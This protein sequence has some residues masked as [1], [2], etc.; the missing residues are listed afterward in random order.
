MKK[1][2]LEAYKLEFGIHKGTEEETLEMVEELDDDSEL[3]QLILEDQLRDKLSEIMLPE[4]VDHWLSFPN[5]ELDG[6]KPIEFIKQGK[7][8]R[9]YDIIDRLRSGQFT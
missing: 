3:K 8:D 5:E 7:I 4:F 1:D 9:I 6:H 2:L